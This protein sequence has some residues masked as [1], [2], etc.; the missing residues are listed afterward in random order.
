MGAAR[1]TGTGSFRRKTPAPRRGAARYATAI[2]RKFA[3]KAFRRPVDERTLDR[4]TTI[5]RATYQQ[6]GKTIEQGVGQAIVV[7]LASPTVS[8]PLWREPSQSRRE[9][10][11]AP[12]DEYSLASRLSYFLWS[13][14]P[15]DELTRLAAKGE[16]R[17]E[18]SAQVRRLLADPRSEAL[19]QNFTGQWLE[20]RDVEHFPIQARTILRDDG[21]PRKTDAEIGACAA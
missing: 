6:P 16:L 2:L 3:T 11:I 19:V 13:T 12:L 1:R 20:V 15:D 9:H 5:A 14:M 18:L 4:L 8:V 10:E 17:K 7:V 21:F